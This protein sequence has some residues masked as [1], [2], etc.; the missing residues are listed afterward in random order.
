MSVVIAAKAETKATPQT[1]GYEAQ[2]YGLAQTV[3]AEC[4][5]MQNTW[6]RYAAKLS[7]LHADARKAFMAELRKHVKQ[8]RE[9]VKA[10]EGKPEHDMYKKAAASAGVQISNLMAVAQAMNNGYVLA[11][12]TDPDTK[13][14]VVNSIGDYVPLL[15]FYSIVAEARLFNDSSAAGGA[16]RPKKPFLDKLKKF[17]LDNQP[18]FAADTKGALELIETMAKL[19]D[20]ANK[21][22]EALV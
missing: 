14:L 7:Q 5:G 13:N 1:A 2:G 19:T 10:Q 11:L 17:I 12:Q 15:P 16:G 6:S 3:I 20:K 22:G 18:D 9:H 8:M 4:K 21:A